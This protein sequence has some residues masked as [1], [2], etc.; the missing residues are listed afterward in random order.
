MWNWWNYQHHEGLWCVFFSSPFAQVPNSPSIRSWVCTWIRETTSTSL[1]QLQWTRYAAKAKM[2]L[3]FHLLHSCVYLKIQ[4]RWLIMLDSIEKSKNEIKE[5]G[6]RKIWS[7][8]PM[9]KSKIEMS[10]CTWK[11]HCCINMSSDSRKALSFFWKRHDMRKIGCL[12]SIKLK[13]EC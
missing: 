13:I 12:L 4:L 1:N 3:F 10:T 5:N 11:T 8:C 7:S 2:I 6:Y 9:R